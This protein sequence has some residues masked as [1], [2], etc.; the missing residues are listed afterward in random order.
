MQWNSSKNAGFSQADKTWLPIN[1]NFEEINVE[2]ALADKDSLFYTYQ[3]LISLRKKE[4]W[5]VEAD[6]KLLDTADKVFAYERQLGEDTYLVVVNV[7]DQEQAFTKD[8]RVAEVI[9]ANTDVNKVLETKRL[10]AWD[11][12][13]IKK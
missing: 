6:F 2:A 11:A 3:K 9:I 5:L 7:S 10:Q 1:P 12:F 13:C 8:L 4:D